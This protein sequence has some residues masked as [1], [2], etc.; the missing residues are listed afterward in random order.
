MAKERPILAPGSRVVERDEYSHDSA[1]E[2]QALRPGSHVR[3]VRF[4]E[5]V[6]K[7]IEGGIKPSVVARF[8]GFGEKRILLEFLEPA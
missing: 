2:G 4:G 1:E 6:V 7:S 5:G 8:P 3:H